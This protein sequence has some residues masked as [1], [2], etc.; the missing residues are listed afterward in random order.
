MKTGSNP[1]TNQAPAKD[2]SRSLENGITAKSIETELTKLLASE[3][4]RHSERM[5][6]FLRLAVEVRLHHEQNHL[7]EYSIG[8]EVFDRKPDFDPRVDP[9]V[10]VEAR[11]LRSK[12]A[13]YYE[14]EGRNDAILIALPKGSYVPVFETHASLPSARQ[15]PLA[16]AGSDRTQLAHGKRIRT[17]Y[18]LALLGGMGL[19]ALL[20]FLSV[21]RLPDKVIMAVRAVPAPK[22]LRY[23]QITN[24]G[25]LKVL[26]DGP[27]PLVTD[28]ARLY[29]SEAAG[30]QSALAEVSASGGQTALIATPLPN[31]HIA[32]ISPRR[33]ELM[34]AA[35][36]G[37]RTELPFWIV[38]VPGTSSRPVASLRG[39][40]GAWSPDGNQIAYA[41][42]QD[43]YVA[44]AD[45]TDSHR[46][47]TIPH[48]SL[49]RWLRWSPNGKSLRFTLD[50]FNSNL[51]T[52]WEAAPDGKD[53]HP[54]LP[55]WNDSPD[56]CCGSW[57][58][59]GRYYLF[60]SS[61]GGWTG[62]WKNIWAIRE[63]P[64]FFHAGGRKPVQLT[65]G[66]LRF[67]G[68]VA[69]L[70][71]KQ[72]FAVGVAPR[73]E[74]VRYDR[75]A[76]QFLPYL[77]GLSAEG[78]S[79]SRDGQ[80][81]TYVTYPDGIL[82]RSKVDGA[83][84][85]QLSPARLW[86]RFP[87]WSPDGKW[88]AFIAA[89]PGEP[90]RIYKVAA[91]GDLLLQLFPGEKD[92]GV[93]TWSQDGHSVVFGGIMTYPGRTIGSLSI[94]CLDLNTHRLSVLPGSEGLW[95]SRYSPNGRYISAVRIDSGK[96][97][98][99]DLRT[100]RWAPLGGAQADDTVW[101]RDSQF[102]YFDVTFG[103]D[104]AV[105]RVRV[106]DHK[107]ERVASLKDL[108]RAGAYSPWLGLAPDGS[109]LVLRD[110]GS[111]EIYALDWE[112]P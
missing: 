28:G 44:N 42:G 65:A 78:V 5:S 100:Q 61:R 47:V 26:P 12:L 3:V 37:T 21:D 94:Q 64:G 74:L 39:H 22:V 83:E 87:Q 60:L 79:F 81:I 88:I 54:L 35:L 4:F 9:I 91:D 27:T 14:T 63:K 108:R 43:L 18:R 1:G 59:D 16:A 11:R 55:G 23:R 72:L 51:H 67:Q 89:T 46:I 84:R 104:P 30:N 49:V 34:I 99:F 40:D 90:W 41:N 73:G 19:I 75:S 13:Q 2:G 57:T 68:T 95:T 109:P 111:Q 58:S 97:V 48:P 62:G 33:S 10:R 25:R 93:P 76:H 80:W 8:L 66:P 53:L 56:E 17:Y 45:G 71:G 77:Q 103:N 110:V 96:L 32:D 6:R 82:W 31:G 86:A 38:P 36:E 7:K 106:S 85:L 92:Q 24:D 69:S 52:L 107:L 29:F 70:D 15:P 50:E 98:L 105:Y 102:V 112:A 101:S 20:V